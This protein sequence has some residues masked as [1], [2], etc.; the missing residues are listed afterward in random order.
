MRAVVGLQTA[1]PAPY[2]SHVPVLMLC[3]SILK[4]Q[5]VLELGCGYY[6][7]PVFLNRELC[8]SVE[9][10]TSV[11]TDDQW[12]GR[13]RALHGH[14]GRWK[15]QLAK[16]GTAQWLG[17]SQHREEL[18]GYDLIFV[19]DLQASSGRPRTLG[20]LLAQKPSCPVVVHDV[21]EWRLRF[22]IWDDGPFVIFDAFTPQT[23]VCNCT[24]SKAK[25]DLK[26]ASVAMRTKRGEALNCANLEDWITVGH[27][28]I[29]R[30]AL[31]RRC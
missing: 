10:L 19:D 24:N 11:E 6:S 5:R 12:L 7:T 23:G 27:D 31:D 17:E 16:D 22:R 1:S 21:E 18:S 15:P 30:A 4:P 25:T 9:Q 13:L 2:G 20:A 29:E 28:A 3:A 14:D 26:A 8:P